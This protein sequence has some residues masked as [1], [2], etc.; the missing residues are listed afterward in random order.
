ML[1]KPEL[2]TKILSGQKTVTRRRLTFSP[3]ETLLAVVPGHRRDLAIEADIAEEIDRDPLAR[4][5]EAI[6]TGYSLRFPDDRA[7]LE[8]QLEIYDALYAWCRLDVAR[9]A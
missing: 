9:N 4:G 3:A 6:A 5:L 7:N 2:V 8:R 1:F